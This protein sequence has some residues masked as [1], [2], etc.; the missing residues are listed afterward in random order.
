MCSKSVFGFLRQS[1]YLRPDVDFDQGID[2]HEPLNRLLAH[3]WDSRQDEGVSVPI[4][5]G[6][7]LRTQRA[8][9]LTQQSLLQ[10]L[11]RA[12]LGSDAIEALATMMGRRTDSELL[13]EFKM[14]RS[15]MTRLPQAES[16]ARRTHYLHQ[17]AQLATL[18]GF[19]GMAAQDLATAAGAGDPTVALML[20][21]LYTCLQDRYSDSQTAMIRA[22]R[23]SGDDKLIYMLITVCG[24]AGDEDEDE[25]EDD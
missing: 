4:V 22:Q 18:E 15:V 23:A 11:L 7:F 14:F 9:I 2:D 8:S 19:E 21:Q 13:E 17:F 20:G 10:V 16:N 12:D 6:L 5:P 1:G 3:Q 24:M 25:D